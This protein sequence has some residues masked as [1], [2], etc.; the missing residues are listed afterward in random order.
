LNPVE[1]KESG[2]S[3]YC[4]EVSDT[5]IVAHI[6]QERAIASGEA[7]EIDE[8]ESEGEEQDQDQEVNLKEILK[9]CNQLEQM[10]LNYAHHKET[11]ELTHHLRHF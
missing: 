10:C 8:S 4:S 6:H 5:E 11:G 3:P 2:D 1:E 9:L 7:M